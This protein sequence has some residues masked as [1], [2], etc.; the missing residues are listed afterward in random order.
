[1][2]QP[3]A[4]LLEALFFSEARAGVD[5]GGLAELLE[6]SEEDVEVSEPEL[7]DADEE[8]E[9]QEDEELG[10]SGGALDIER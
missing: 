2:E 4:R 3:L 5:A 6:D 1:L 10:G 9:E 8:S 7:S